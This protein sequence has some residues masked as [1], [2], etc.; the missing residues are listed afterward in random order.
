MLQRGTDLDFCKTKIGHN[1]EEQENKYSCKITHAIKKKA[2]LITNVAQ[3]IQTFFQFLSYLTQNR[4][5]PIPGGLRAQCGDTLDTLL[6][7]WRAQS[8]THAHT[9]D[10]LDKSTKFHQVTYRINNSFE[11]LKA[12]SD[13]EDLIWTISHSSQ[14]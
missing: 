3:K 6:T 8:H 2:S 12:I 9:T 13:W 11:S 4:R 7:H 5:E 1:T 10:N 14:L